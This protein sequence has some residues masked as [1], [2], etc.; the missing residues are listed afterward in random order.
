MKR[1][2]SSPS[3]AQAHLVQGY[4]EQA[5][6]KGIVQGGE[7]G[8]LLGALPTTETYSSVWV[9]DE[10]VERAEALV[11]EFL[12][13]QSAEAGATLWRCPGCG[14]YLEPQFTDCWNCGA[15]RVRLP[16]GQ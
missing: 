5:G 12:Q 15:S 14:E 16:D 7:L 11:E 1:V 4:L 9:A 8:G 13:S 2:Y 10:A 6:V 3:P